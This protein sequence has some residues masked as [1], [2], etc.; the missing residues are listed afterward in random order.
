MIFFKA[1]GVNMMITILFLLSKLDLIN[2]SKLISKSIRHE[3]KQMIHEQSSLKVSN[4][5]NVKKNELQ[6]IVFI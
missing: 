5:Q 2:K 6:N 1:R 4:S 3:K